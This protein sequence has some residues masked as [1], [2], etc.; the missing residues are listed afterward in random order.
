VDTNPKAQNVYDTTYKQNI[1]SIEG[2]KIRGWMLQA[3][4]GEGAAERTI[5]GNGR[6]VIKEEKRRRRK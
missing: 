6:K 2:R 5:V 3:C 1:W 4:M